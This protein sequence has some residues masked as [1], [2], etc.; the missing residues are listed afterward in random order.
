MLQRTRVAVLIAA[1]S[2]ATALR[3][4]LE[5]EPD[6][7]WSDWLDPIEFRIHQRPE[8]A[9]IYDRLG[10]ADSAITVFERYLNARVLYRSDLDAFH[11]APTL[12]RLST[13]YHQRN[14]A[15][16]ARH[17]SERLRKMWRDADPQL[18]QFWG[19]E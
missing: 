6:R 9:R 8:L 7:V 4:L 19:M 18:K 13:L 11:L 17:Y 16:R 14:E 1:D 10:Q 12:K 15:A 5:R 3:V 2:A